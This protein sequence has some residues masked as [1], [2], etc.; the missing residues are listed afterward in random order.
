[1]VTIY[2]VGTTASGQ[3]Y[4]AQELIRGRSLD[5]VE[6]PI[7]WRPLCEIAIGVARGLHAAHRCG[8]LHRDVKPAN[9]MLDERGTAKLLDFGIAKLAASSDVVVRAPRPP[10]DDVAATQ[11][12]PGAPSVV[13]STPLAGSPTKP[14][15][16]VGTPRYAAPELWRGESATERSDL[17]S[18]GVML[19]ELAAA[20]PPFPQTEAGP[21]RDAVLA[22]GARPIDELAADMPR[23]FATAIMRCLTLDPEDRPPSASELAHSLELILVE[24]PSLLPEGNPYR[25][26]APFGAAHRGRFFGRGV[27][28]RTLVDRLRG[29]PLLAIVGDSGIGKSSLCHAGIVPEVVAG[30]L[31]DGRRWRAVSLVPGRS[32]WT[33]FVAACGIAEHAPERLARA[34]GGDDA[35]TLVVIDQLEELVTTSDADEAANLARLLGEIGGGIRGVKALVTVRGDFLTRVATLPH[36]GEVL[37]R[38]AHVLR[39]LARE[40]L[41]DAIVG[42]ARGTSVR[43]END[44]MVDRLIDAV[45]DT[46]G[47]LPLLQFALAA[48]WEAHDRE[49]GVISAAALERLGGVDGALATH[50]DAV[51]RGL[52]ADA[53]TVARRILVRLVGPDRTR[54]IRDR[55]ELGGTDAATDVA[56]EALV[57]GR[58]VVARDSSEGTATYELAHEALIRS[59]GTLRDLLAD[60]AGQLA[61]RNRLGA[62]ATE[63]Q[64]LDRRAELLWTKRQL[65]ELHALEH[66]TAAETAFVEASRRRARRQLLARI[67]V[68]VA[69]PAIAIGVVFLV[70][71]AADRERARAVEVHLDASAGHL[72]EAQQLASRASAARRDALAAFVTQNN[73]EPAW[74]DA[75]RLAHEADAQY[76][77]AAVELEAAFSIDASAVRSRMVAVLDAHAHLASLVRDANRLDELVHRLAAYDPARA[78]RWTRPGRLELSLDRPASIA[79]HAMRAGATSRIAG[80]F[81]AA[82]IVRVDGSRLERE[83]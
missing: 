4:I 19:Y 73:G 70:R 61:V 54:A 3:P 62:A 32:P 48:L 2:R 15:G 69:V 20:T 71:Q 49:R 76:R 79:I 26:L 24:A 27:D 10:S 7:A 46:P 66:P 36:L 51:L 21:L 29:E 9:V 56:L 64:R 40:D 44:A 31:G 34:L 50:A 72:K 14:G 23:A 80:G 63:W 25:G 8:V 75:Q 67:A 53:R 12:V 13:E 81:D 30:A 52:P 35:G 17:Y 47:A 74:A 38:G 18:L 6:R 83:L 42:P 28:I 82:P 59:W 11:D 58:L 43:F 33:A 45:A 60:E 37:T 22:G 41:R 5:A 16:L 1:M 78:A 39:V 65:A 55:G 57:K 77:E 68:V